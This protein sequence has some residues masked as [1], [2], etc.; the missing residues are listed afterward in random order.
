MEKGTVT[1]IVPVY[2][3]QDFATTAPFDWLYER[4]SQRFVLRQ[5]VDQMEQNAKD[6]GY[7]AFKGAWRDYLADRARKDGITLENVTEFDGQDFELLCGNYTCDDA[8]IT[9]KDRY[10]CEVMVCDHPLM[11]VRRLVNVDTGE[12]KIEIAFKRRGKWRKMIFD[13]ETLSNAQK[14]TQLA[15]YG[16]AVDSENNRD[17]VRYL[18][19][20]ENMN[21]DD[22]PEICSVGRL[23]WIPEYGFSPY[24]ENLVFD[25][26]L[27]FKSIFDAVQPCGE[28]EK[29][30][31]CVKEI[32]KTSLIARIILAASFSSV[33]IEICGGLPYFVHLWGG[34]E[35]GKTVALMLGAS[36]WANPSMGRYI[37]TFNSTSVGQEMMAGF[38]NSLPLCID[39]LQIINDKG[40]NDGTIH[41]LTEGVGKSRGSR[42][43]GLQR[44]QTWKNCIITTGESPINK[45]NSGG[46]VVNRIIDIDCKDEKIFQDPHGVVEVVS[47]NYGHAGKYLISM[48][49]NET[50]IPLVKQMQRENYAKLMN[51]DT[52]EKQAQAA[53][54]IL[55]ADALMELILFNDG[56]VL[57]ASDF[58]PYLSTKKEVSINDRAYDW[59]LGWVASNPA[60]FGKSEIVEQ[61][62]V[63]SDDFAY[64]IKGVFDKVMQENGFDSTAFLSWASR[65]GKIERGDKMTKLKR[66]S[67]Y[68]RPVRCVWLRLNDDFEELPEDEE[69]PFSNGL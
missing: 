13:K 67:C 24:V 6:V 51:G 36:V 30:M 56:I 20:L 15:K 22:I 41:K 37:H 31:S 2:T 50:M 48:F 53:S 58:A 19:A 55:T 65:N 5:Y 47:Q 38:C 59:L 29:W 44:M 68:E 39:E 62:G 32:R 16:I 45:P 9:I 12:V 46:G 66:L 52:T 42:S 4:K 40:S 35:A 8:G 17:M 43:G 14:I 27:C 63:V 3:R 60:R 34:T 54:I 69:T 28:A 21:Y 18:S 49:E 61:Y 33:L 26:D 1:S 25:G 11:P 64:I 23:G 7:K 10:D 57:N